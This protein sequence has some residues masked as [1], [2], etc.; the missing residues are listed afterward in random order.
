MSRILLAM[1]PSPA[2]DALGEAL[3]AAGQS[4]VPMAEPELEAVAGAQAHV[5]L[6][7]VEAEGFE[8]ASALCIELR[9]HEATRFVPVALVQ[10][11]HPKGERSAAA[12]AAGAREV[13]SL[14]D[15]LELLV[16]RV[17][18]L[19]RL[20]YLRRSYRR[21][22]DKVGALNA[23]LDQVFEVAA[24]ACFIVNAEGR[25]RR[26]NA[27]ARGLLEPHGAAPDLLALD[28]VGAIDACL[29]GA[30]TEPQPCTVGEAELILEVRP[31][32][33]PGG[34][35]LGALGLLRHATTGAT[36][37]HA[38]QLEAAALARRSEEVEAFAYKAAHDMK[39]PLWS[40]Q[41]Y[42]AE[43][44]E[45]A[46]DEDAKHFLSRIEV[47]AKRCSGLVQGMVELVKLRKSQLYIEACEL[48]GVL[49]SAQRNLADL[50]ERSGARIESAA[51]PVV[52]GDFDLLVDLFTHLLHNAMTY[53]R[54][55]RPCVIEVGVE[56][57]T[58][59]VRDNGLGIAPADH[60][61]IF[62]VFTRLHSRDR[63]EGSG[64][65][66]RMARRIVARQQGR[67]WVE[68]ELGEGATFFLRL[69]AP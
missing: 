11:D 5:V 56:G 55:D 4:V 17:D 22:A 3:E 69:P 41:R 58:V 44:I 61:R 66:L 29:R 46:T 23:E 50:I 51:L 63:I 67:L 54:P 26:I 15:P 68:S 27:R 62:D 33:A 1:A 20:N 42:A 14:A 18:N 53:R 35:V 43:L 64:L 49:R 21:Q 19:A 38:L 2:R 57:E 36:Y 37:Q 40:I 32:L 39:S 9:R 45:D 31:L 52:Q 25:V 16:A 6:L 12:F 34:R 60:E 48:D 8:A 30:P 47:N 28:A 59:F 10:A 7:G 65:G 13:L 24:E